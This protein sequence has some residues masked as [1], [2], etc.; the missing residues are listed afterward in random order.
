MN[1]ELKAQ[2][3]EKLIPLYKEL[4]LEFGD[5]AFK[6][7]LSPFYVQI[8][9]E[10]S[11]GQGLLFVGKATNGWGI[12]PTV[13]ELFENFDKDNSEEA[14]KWV[15]DQGGSKNE[16]NTSRSAFLRVT[17]NIAWSNLCK[18]AP[19]DGGNPNNDDFYKQ[20]EICQRILSAEIDILKPKAVI[21]FT[22]DWNILDFSEA[23]RID[24]VKW[25]NTSSI[26]YNLKGVYYIHSVHPQGKI[27][28]EHKNAIETLLNHIGNSL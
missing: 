10:W 3:K 7:Y 6:E 8:G 18:V 27:E 14:L 17:K 25:G 5:E 22:S 23:S 24:E 11:A 20:K 26:L 2:L 13:E 4:Y 16:C 12:S 9:S 1:I 21:L 28:E 19:V 15:E